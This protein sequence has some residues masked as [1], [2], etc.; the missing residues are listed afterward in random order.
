VGVER[1][2]ENRGKANIEKT[3]IVEFIADG[4]MPSRCRDSRRR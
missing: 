2:R 1:E 3:G 4:D